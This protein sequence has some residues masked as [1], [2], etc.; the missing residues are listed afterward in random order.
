LRSTPG[1][2]DFSQIEKTGLP[3]PAAYYSIVVFIEKRQPKRTFIRMN[4]KIQQRHF[5]IISSMWKE[6]DGMNGTGREETGRKPFLR[7]LLYPFTNHI[8]YLR[9]L[10]FNLHYFPFRVAVRLPVILYRGVRLISTKG[11]IELDFSPVKPGCIKIGKAR[12]GFHSRYHHTIWEQREGTV[13]FG[14]D[15]LI[16]KGTFFMIGENATLRFGHNVGFGGNDKVI[17]RKSIVIGDHTIAAWDVQII[18]TDFHP[19]V[20]TVFKTV[21]CAEK[22]ITIGNY[23]WL[24]FGST[25]LKGSVTPDHCIVSANT[26]IKSDFS[27]AGENIVLGYEPGAK[28]TAR[29]VRFDRT[30]LDSPQDQAKPEHKL[31]AQNK[32]SGNVKHVG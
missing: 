3:Y 20:N 10:Y 12:Y 18:D 21:N 22:P 14:K 1:K 26:T 5:N 6:E 32:P 30:S 4:K 7:I 31:P 29:Y 13:I 25:I 11:R 16:G 24:G 19:T 23:N 9:T 8:S 2:K 28:V 27:D 17:C 15:I